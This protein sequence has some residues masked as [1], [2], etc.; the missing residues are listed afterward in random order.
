MIRIENLQFVPET[1]EDVFE[2]ENYGMN[3][4]DDKFWFQYKQ[5]FPSWAQDYA[6]LVSFPA[7]RLLVLTMDVPMRALAAVI[8]YRKEHPQ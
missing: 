8:R 3:M 5:G 6:D 7:H 1:E 4:A 2:L